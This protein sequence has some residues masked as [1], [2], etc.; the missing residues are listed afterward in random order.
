MNFKNEKIRGVVQKN[1]TPRA[2]A[3][4]LSAKSKY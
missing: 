1:F 2:G 3:Q 4:R